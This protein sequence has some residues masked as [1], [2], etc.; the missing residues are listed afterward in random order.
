M[1]KLLAKFMKRTVSVVVVSSFYHILLN[2][3]CNSTE[4]SYHVV[5]IENRIPLPKEQCN[6]GTIRDLSVWHIGFILASPSSILC[7]I[8]L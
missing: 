3:L 2:F 6:E 4:Q 5:K 1:H 7:T 8:A